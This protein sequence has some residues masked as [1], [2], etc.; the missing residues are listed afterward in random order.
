MIIC[1]CKSLANAPS[2][3][4]YIGPNLVRDFINQR[5]RLDRALCAVLASPNEL[6]SYIRTIARYVVDVSNND[7]GLS[8][9]S[10][11]M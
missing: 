3:Y 9:D 1:S 7:T 11:G 8:N 2:I 10:T 6:H 4:L 5:I